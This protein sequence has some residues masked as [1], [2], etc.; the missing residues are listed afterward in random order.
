MPPRRRSADDVNVSLASVSRGA[1]TTRRR[2]VPWALSTGFDGDVD[3]DRMRPDL[4]CALV[5]TH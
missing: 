2:S 1:S 3:H 5:A 4:V